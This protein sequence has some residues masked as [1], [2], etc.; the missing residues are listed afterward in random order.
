MAKVREI[1][2]GLI[3]TFRSILTSIVNGH[4]TMTTNESGAS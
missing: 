3:V 1:G 2:V 4:I